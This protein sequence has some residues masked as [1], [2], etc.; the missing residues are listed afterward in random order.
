[1]QATK[2]HPQELASAKREPGSCTPA[3]AALISHLP[4]GTAKRRTGRRIDGCLPP[5]RASRERTG[6]ARRGG[7][8]ESGPRKREDG[9]SPLGTG[10]RPSGDEKQQQPET[11]APFWVS[12]GQDR[13]RAAPRSLAPQRAPWGSSGA[14]PGRPASAPLGADPR[15]SPYLPQHFPAVGTEQVVGG[16]RRAAAAP[17]HGGG[18]RP[19]LG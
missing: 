14:S 15:P 19:R 4:P 5:P 13:A 10:F 12:A 3:Q 11:H 16:G 1:M 18:R 9:G 17:V 7:G 6:E 2:H 8:L